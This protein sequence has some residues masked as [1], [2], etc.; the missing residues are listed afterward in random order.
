MNPSISAGT[1]YA[2]SAAFHLTDFSTLLSYLTD[3]ASA[4]WA[5]KYATRYRYVKVLLMS[6]EKDDLDV[7][8]EIGPLESVFRGLYH[9]DTERWK[10]PSRRPTVEVSRK[11]ADLVE[12]HGREGNLLIFYYGGHA[13]P[14]EQPGGSPVWVANRTRDSPTVPSSVFRSLLGEVDCDVILLYDCYHTFHAGEAFPGKGVVET[15]AA[16]EFDPVSPAPGSHP[17]T[18]ALVQE[19]ARAAHTTDWLSVVELHRRLINRLQSGRAHVKFTDGTYSV[20][21][22]D[23]HIGQPIFETPRRRMPIYSF[24]SKKPRTVSLIP[25]PPQAQRQR[26]EPLVLLN[27]PTRQP[28]VIPDGPGVLVACSLR[29][30]NVDVEKWKGWLLNTPQGAQSI[31]IAAIYPG[32]S[33]IL[34]L[35]LPLLVWDLLPPS[36]AIS[37][38]AYTTGQDHAS[39]FRRALAHDLDESTATSDAE[40]ED[41]QESKAGKGAKYA[42]SKRMKRY[43]F[44]GNSAGEKRG[45]SLWP[46]LFDCDRTAVY[47]MEDEPY[48]LNLVGMQDSEGDSVSLTERII[49]AFVRDAAAPSSRHI[50]DEVEAFC[51]PASFDAL[52]RG[53]VV[54]T[55]LVAILDERSP[56]TCPHPRTDGV[57][58]LSHSQLFEA[59]SRGGTF[60]PP[61]IETDSKS[62][63]FSPRRRLIY[64]TNLDPS[65]T[66][67]LASTASEIQ[68]R[69]LREFVYKHITF[70]PGID[71]KLHSSGSQTLGFQLAFHLPF[72]AW[73][74]SNKT[75]LG[76]RLG[77]NRRRLRNSRNL[78]FLGR[79]NGMAQTY[80]HEA[81]ISCMIVGVDNRHWTA[82]GFFD[83][84]H[85]GGESKHDVQSYQSAEGARMMD[86]LT[87]GRHALDNPIWTAREYFLLLVESCIQEVK[88][89]WQNV[90][91]HL[92]KVFRSYAR[93]SNGIDRK[94]A[95]KVAH[96]VI[97]VLEQLIDGLSGTIAAWE[98]FVEGDLLY[99]DLDDSSTVEGTKAL[100]TSKMVENIDKGITEMR[101]LRES[102]RRQAEMFKA[103]TLTL[104]ALSNIRN[105]EKTN[106]LLA[107]GL[108]L[109]PFALMALVST[110]KDILVM[111]LTPS[112]YVI[113]SAG[114]AC[115]ATALFVTMVNWAAA[116]ESAGALLAYLAALREGRVLSPGVKSK[117]DNVWRRGWWPSAGP[118]FKRLPESDSEAD[119]AEASHALPF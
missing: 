62:D 74:Q 83:T 20:V 114:V 78:G 54:S 26:E 18:G 77:G 48:C 69:F 4:A 91:Q 98:R 3:A 72:F 81:Q 51:S 60:P 10:I 7:E 30:Q 45:P 105:G 47:A 118:Q 87:G 90:E 71:V 84:H 32:F 52:S 106:A 85:D 110:A 33:T 99:F 63:R 46:R 13:R 9:Y 42:G 19:L 70:Q 40:S 25:L 111:Q 97:L 8:V 14:N 5:D 64:V 67:A 24:L 29:D 80:I 49:R 36:R 65:S 102:L 109:L 17:F 119:P 6:W 88:E 21:Q 58:F 55:E 27:P 73:R 35:K 100:R 37:F 59:S 12:T 96:Q 23:R 117:I 76:T 108:S 66:L 15:L 1:N 75:A 56:P 41:D 104:L 89:E 39:D 82:Y 50:S 11:V 34:V 61:L 68:V 2:S 93:D 22:V 94:R 31:E 57:R 95:Q 92:L 28:E 38:I 101:V 107:T 103:S 16:G 79:A 86:P 116:T 115:L 44:L 43:A 53:Q 113:G 112:R